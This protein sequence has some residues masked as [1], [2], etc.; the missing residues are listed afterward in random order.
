MLTRFRRLFAV[1]CVLTGAGLL[2]A[3]SNHSSESS[4]P[5]P[6]PEAESAADRAGSPSDPA[7]DGA[8]KSVYILPVR[9]QIG[10][11]IEYILRRGMKEAVTEGIDLVV[12]DMNTPG[13]RLNTTLE[14][15]EMMA[16]FDGT[17]L[18]FVNSDAISAGAFIAASTKEIYFAPRGVMGAAAPVT[19]TGEDIPEAMKQKILSFLKARIRSFTEEVPYR[20]DVL[21]AMVDADFELVIDDEVISPE[22]ELLTVTASE[23]V[24]KYGDPAFPLLAQGIYDDIESLLDD[25]FGA[26]NYVIKEFHVTWSEHVTQYISSIAPLLI[27]VGLVMLYLEAQSPGFGIFGIIGVTAL[28]IFFLGN[29]AAGL[30][31]YEPVLF[32]LLGLAFIAVEVFFFPGTFIFAILGA[33]FILG[34]LIYGMADIWPEEGFGFSPEVLVAPTLNVF[35]GLILAVVIAVVFARVVPRSWFLDRLILNSAIA[36]S[37]QGALVGDPPQQTGDQSNPRPSAIP[38][39]PPI[40]SNGR[41]VTD[42]FPSGEIEIDGKRFQ[43]RAQYGSVASGAE[44]EVAGYGD[45]VL[46]VREAS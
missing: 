31:G 38:G 13:G 26:G 37:S 20:A 3:D 19:A 2:A 9:D 39:K 30:A 28:A 8:V 41:A 21:T 43:A 5:D 45:F 29:Y 33:L 46:I 17:T 23:A 15:M 42:L 16:R 10:R 12:L 1:L 22:G 14:I 34:S 35:G 27:G 11:P 36:G 7:G 24:R 44:I 18:T 32:F 40:G 6:E 25:R 4:S